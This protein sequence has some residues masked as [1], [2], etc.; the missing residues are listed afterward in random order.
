MSTIDQ[1]RISTYK[2]E[3]LEAQNF[4]YQITSG[5]INE[6]IIDPFKIR[7]LKYTIIVLVEAISNLAR[8][9]LAKKAHVVIEE[10]M[11][12][13][14]KM[15]EKGFLTEEISKSL[16]PLIKLGHQL[17]H[18]YWKTDDRRLFLETK[19]TLNK[20]KEFISEID[21]IIINSQF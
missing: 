17:I 21:K 2:A 1:E 15:Q 6:F 11:E 8:H 14:L 7:A 16:I 9:I 19:N 3:I 12:A 20:I 10:Y 4:L 13:L 18:G 5:E